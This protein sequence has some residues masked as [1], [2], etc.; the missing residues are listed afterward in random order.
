MIPIPVPHPNPKHKWTT[1]QPFHPLITRSSLQWMI[2]QSGMYE[3]HPCKKYTYLIDYIFDKSPSAHEL[4]FTNCDAIEVLSLKLLTW[5]DNKCLLTEKP[6]SNSITMT[7]LEHCLWWAKKILFLHAIIIYHFSD[8]APVI[9]N[10]N[11]FHFRLNWLKEDSTILIQVFPL[12]GFSWGLIRKRQTHFAL[13][14]VNTEHIQ[15]SCYLMLD[16]FEWC[17]C[18]KTF[19]VVLTKFQNF[20]INKNTVLRKTS[21]VCIYFNKIRPRVVDLSFI[22]I[23]YAETSVRYAPNFFQD[24]LILF[25]A[26]FFKSRLQKIT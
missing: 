5:I 18:H 15:K 9:I 21:C 6:L 1:P 10:P 19:L 4:S 26:I 17:L 16:S 14:D 2:F 20:F 12:T 3:W 13:H 11:I 23:F 8:T 22:V 25:S 7:N 24:L